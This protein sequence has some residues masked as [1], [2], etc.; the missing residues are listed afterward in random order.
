MHYF[1]ANTQEYFRTIGD[2]MG[3]WELNPAAIYLLLSLV[4]AVI[5]SCILV[6]MYNKARRKE[7]PDPGGNFIH[8]DPDDI[9]LFL[10]Q[11]LQDRSK[12]ELSLNPNM[13]TSRICSLLEFDSNTLTLEMPVQGNPPPQGW[14][15]KA[16]YVYFSIPTEQDQRLYFFFSSQILDITNTQDSYCYLYIS[17]PRKL[18]QK[19]RR[20]AFRIEPPTA[21]IS[22]IQLWNCPNATLPNLP[23]DLQSLGAPMLEYPAE[24]PKAEQQLLLQNISATG[25]R[26]LVPRTLRKKIA[27]DP[28]NI[29]DLYLFLQLKNPDS[30]GESSFCLVCRKRNFYLDQVSRDLE[31]GLQIIFHGKEQDS[32]QPGLS[33]QKVD[34][35]AGVPE[36][37]NWVFRQHLKIFR[38]KGLS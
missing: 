6:H 34:P 33:W 32:K 21:Q 11:A 9:H 13:K 8:K 1:S 23:Q 16:I 3:N 12:F 27:L 26:I 15:G 14:V 17:F 7:I 29:L 28:D 20:E 37:G 10:Q 24:S 2:S 19:Q 22:R 36:L 18:E 25:L 38:E 4:S 35:E 31:L 5:A 30:A